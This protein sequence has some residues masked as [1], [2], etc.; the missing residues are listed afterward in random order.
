MMG[1]ESLSGHFTVTFDSQPTGCHVSPLGY[2]DFFHFGEIL[3]VDQLKQ[4][5][6]RKSN[7][8]NC[9]EVYTVSMMVI[10]WFISLRN[11]ISSSV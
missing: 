7:I 2:F 11:A 1:F 5:K 3:A 6:V 9:Y 4:T 8:A 10:Y